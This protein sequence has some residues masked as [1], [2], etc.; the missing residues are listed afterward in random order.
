MYPAEKNGFYYLE[1]KRKGILREMQQPLS[2]Q[3]LA[4]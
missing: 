4:K 3:D 2:Q 1:R